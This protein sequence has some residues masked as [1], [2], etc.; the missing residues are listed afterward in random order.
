MNLLAD[1][2]YVLDLVSRHYGVTVE[3]ITGPTR[4]ARPAWARQVVMYILQTRGGLGPVEIGIAINRDHTTVYHGIRNV[5]GRI[6]VERVERERLNDALADVCAPDVLVVEVSAALREARAV[7]GRLES[8]EA[9]LEQRSGM[10][11]GRTA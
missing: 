5:A 3:E 8:L 10:R 11:I 2:T 7:V 9:V 4:T 1:P 6:R